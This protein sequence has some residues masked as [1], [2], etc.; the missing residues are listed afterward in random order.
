MLGV[1]EQRAI[2]YR[3]ACL[4]GAGERVGGWGGTHRKW[5]ISLFLSPHPVPGAAGQRSQSPW[6]QEAQGPHSGPTQAVDTRTWE[7]LCPQSRNQLLCKT[8]IIKEWWAR[9]PDMARPGFKSWL[10]YF[11]LPIR[12]TDHRASVL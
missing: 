11:P 12:K 9:A 2:V 7:S 3:A 8:V 10:P 5:L 1:G 6:P 4:P